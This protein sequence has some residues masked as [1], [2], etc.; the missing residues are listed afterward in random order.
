MVSIRTRLYAAAL[1]IALWIAA[2]IPAFAERSAAPSG[3][4]IENFGRVNEGYFRG[5]QPKGRDYTDLA[6]IG[7]KTVIDLSNEDETEAQ[8][9]ESAGMKFVRIP[10][11][12]T[13]A[14][15]QAA[16]AKFLALVND[17]VNQPV[18]VHCQGGRHRTGVMT[19]IYRMTH[20][21]WTPDRAFAEMLQYQ[22]KKGWVSHDT[23]KNFVYNFLPKSAEVV[24]MSSGGGGRN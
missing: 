11:T 10:L 20:D 4:A 22:F 1:M 19:A 17:P 7:V 3:I 18:Y 8:S 15:A 2:P 21:H 16:V 13:A 6:A 23:L 14:P 5:A 9:V 24:A 12:T